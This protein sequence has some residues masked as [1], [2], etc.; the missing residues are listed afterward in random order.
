MA[1]SAAA[2]YGA[3]AF[4]GLVEG[5]IPGGPETTLVPG[6]TA[7]V[8][9]TALLLFGPR[10][11]LPALAAL[12]PIGATLIAIALESTSGAGDGAA[13]YVWPVLWQSYFFGRRGTIMIVA[14]VAVA[15][16]VAL[17]MMPPG[18][19]Y[20][21]RWVDVIVSM[22][23]VGGV[24]D[25]LAKSNERLVESLAAEARVDQLTGL[26]N[27]RGFLEGANAELARARRTG[28]IVVAVSFDIDRFKRTNDEWGHEAGDG[29]L[30]SLGALLR[31]ETRESDL[32]ARVGGEE[33]V[34][35]LCSSDLS[36]ALQYAERVRTGFAGLEVPDAPSSTLSAG[37]A[38]EVAPD[39]LQPLL[40]QADTALY[41]AKAQ[42]RNRT[43][44][45]GSGQTTV[46]QPV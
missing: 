6:F 38:A 23:V 7:L 17:Q 19:G 40:G 1:Y 20:M 39:E 25:L 10:M 9:V 32:V 33:F 42:G 36:E 37:V 12:G 4:T 26:L 28:S 41:A 15:H 8:L 2:M 34:T 14:W 5:F 43:V 45:S 21:D 3:A 30:A 46:L 11:P 27:R 13:L 29:V 35:L 16:F 31:E 44:V 18:V 24:V 22:I